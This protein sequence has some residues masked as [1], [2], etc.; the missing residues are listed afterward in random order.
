MELKK[1]IC[2]KSCLI[3]IFFMVSM[4]YFTIKGDD[5][6]FIQDFKDTLNEEQLEKYYSIKNERLSIYLRGYFAGFTLALIFII[7]KYYTD[8]MISTL[9]AVCLTL[10][11]SY[12]CSY[13]YYILHKKSDYMIL[14]LDK[15]NQREE[16]LNVYTTMQRNH[17]LGLLFGL[18]A[19]GFLTFSVC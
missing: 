3:A 15:Q 7:L 9:E 11:S 14:Y 8:D 12:F 2:T 4:F 18:L 19:V 17:H 13:F 1:T 6:Q 16:W 10:S 5:Y